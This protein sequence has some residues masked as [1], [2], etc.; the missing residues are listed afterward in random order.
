MIKIEFTNGKPALEFPEAETIKEAVEMAGAKKISLSKAD[1][2]GADLSKA[3]LRGADLSG[4]D[5]LVADLSYTCLIGADLRGADLSGANLRG[6]DLSRANLIGAD[7]RGADLS[8]ADLLVADL[9][10][11]CLIGADLR[12]A[13][14]DY[15][16]C[17]LRCASL[18]AKIDKRLFVQ[19]LYHV[20][21]AGQSVEDE[22]VRK[23][24]DLPEVIK[25]AN[26][27]HRMKECGEIKKMK[28]AGK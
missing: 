20:V 27:F 1:L 8:G 10:Y 19:L 12:G 18:T 17:P 5:L 3:D 23:F 22:E 15:S 28:G 25:L 26:Q 2:R 13:N 11:T 24:L 4:A 21:R 16:C 9:S 6:A 14:L 7:L